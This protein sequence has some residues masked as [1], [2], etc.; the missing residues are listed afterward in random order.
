M[1][2]PTK[3]RSTKKGMKRPAELSR[4]MFWTG[5]NFGRNA[6]GLF[7]KLHPLTSPINQSRETYV[8]RSVTSTKYQGPISIA[9]DINSYLVSYKDPDA[10]FINTTTEKQ[11]KQREMAINFGDHMSE[12]VSTM[13][14]KR[15]QLRTGFISTICSHLIEIC[16]KRLA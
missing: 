5:W 4:S 13:N 9:I 12:V 16:P 7:T 11:E 8:P 10:P 15:N 14:T 3:N 2:P 1:T 6:Y